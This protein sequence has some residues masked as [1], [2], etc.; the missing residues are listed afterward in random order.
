[1]IERDVFIEELA[2]FLFI[3]GIFGREVEEST[4][5]KIIEN[6]LEQIELVETLINKINKEAKKRRYINVEKLK[7]LLLELERIRIELDFENYTKM[8]T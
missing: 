2:G 8:S 4:I 5:R 3:Y 6:S 7:E 1:M